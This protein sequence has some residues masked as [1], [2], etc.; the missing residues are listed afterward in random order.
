MQATLRTIGSLPNSGLP[1]S[2]H[3]SS[4]PTTKRALVHRIKHSLLVR[5]IR[6]ADGLINRK[7]HSGD[8]QAPLVT[9]GLLDANVEPDAPGA[10]GTAGADD[11]AVVPEAEEVV[12]AALGPLPALELGVAGRALVTRD[13]SNLALSYRTVSHAVKQKE[14]D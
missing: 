4:Q 14:K 12:L 6:A 3:C 7:Y 11:Q 2:L 9:T 5:G 8:G 1:P 13:V 10:A